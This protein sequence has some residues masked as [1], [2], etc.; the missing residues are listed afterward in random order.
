MVLTNIQLLRA[1]AAILVVLHHALPHYRSMGGEFSL[2]KSVA[3]WGFTGVDLF[4]VISGFV[5]AHTTLNKPRTLESA[6]IFSKKRFTRIFLGYWPFFALFCLTTWIYLPEKIA[7]LDIIGSFFLTNYSQNELLLPISWSLSYEMYFYAMF[8]LMFALPSVW[9]KRLVVVLF[10]GMSARVLFL[11]LYHGTYWFFFTSPF[12]LEFFAGTAVYLCR[13]FL[14]FRALIPIWALMTVGAFSYGVMEGAHYGSMRVLTFGT[15]AAALL[16]L[17][18]SLEHNGV[19]KAGKSLVAIGDASY[20]IYLS[21]L[22]FLQLF[23]FS[24]LRNWLRDLPQLITELGFVAFIAAVL[25]S[26]HLIY[27]YFELPIYRWAISRRWTDLVN[28]FSR[29]TGADGASLKVDQ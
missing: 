17:A 20:T 2:F 16:A 1:W 18:Y 19:F 23:F 6:L 28:I 12:L 24:G 25:W 5:I 27:R 26:S 21:H 7:H 14:R 22:I 10:V 4:F 29:Y 9:V 8:T 15:A 13:D 11:P 3:H